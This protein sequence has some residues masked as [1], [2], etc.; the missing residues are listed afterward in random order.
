MVYNDRLTRLLV[1]IHE[2][3]LGVLSAN[4][5]DGANIRIEMT[6]PRRLRDDLI[7]I[8]DSKD[9]AHKLAATSGDDNPLKE[10]KFAAQRFKGV[11]EKGQR[12]SFRASVHG[13]LDICR[14]IDKDDVQTDGTKIDSHMQS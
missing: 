14:L 5:D 11:Q 7:D 10:V 4:F 1:S 3:E 8:W 12:P 2:D 6:G 9:V 13:D